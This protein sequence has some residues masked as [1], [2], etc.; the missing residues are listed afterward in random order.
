MPLSR[1]HKLIIGL[2]LGLAIAGFVDATYLTIEHYMGVIPPCVLTTGCDTVTTSSYSTLFGIYVALYGAFYYLALMVFCIH[3]MSTS[4]H[5]LFRHVAQLSW[6]G[7]AAAIYFTSLQV[8]VIRAYCIYCLTSATI[9]TALFI[10]AHYM[11]REHNRHI[12]SF[13]SNA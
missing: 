11:W 2:L 6:I 3:I 5:H 9:S 8:F 7:L 1:N 10:F 12:K 4:R 13:S